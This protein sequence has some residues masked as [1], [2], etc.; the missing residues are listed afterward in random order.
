MC[1]NVCAAVRLENARV[2]SKDE[3]DRQL[4]FVRLFMTRAELNF[5][6]AN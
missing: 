3:I 6:F 1:A 2:P 4:T 5:E